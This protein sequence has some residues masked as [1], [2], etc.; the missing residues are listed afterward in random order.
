MRFSIRNEV[1][2]EPKSRCMRRRITFEEISMTHSVRLEI[3][4]VS[5]S[6]LQFIERLQRDSCEVMLMLGASQDTAPAPYSVQ[7]RVTFLTT[8]VTAFRSIQHFLLSF[9][10]YRNIFIISLEKCE[11]E[12]EEGG[13]C[14]IRSE[15]GPV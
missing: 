1:E 6:A 11:S 12:R 7:P 2:V 3:W 10:E 9:S 5:V 4:W 13:M 15:Q 14:D 8:V